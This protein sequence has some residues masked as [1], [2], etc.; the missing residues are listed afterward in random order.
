MV[1]YHVVTYYQLMWVVAYH[2]TRKKDSKAVIV[3][4]NSLENRLSKA[5][6]SKL[7]DA[8]EIHFFPY[9]KI[10]D[11]LN[12]LTDEQ[13]SQNVTDQAIKLYD[14]YIKYDLN[15]FEEINIAGYHFYFSLVLTAREIKFNIIEEAAGMLSRHHIL[16]S[17]VEKLN[18][19]QLRIALYNNLLYGDNELVQN[20]FCRVECQ[21]KGYEGVNLCNYDLMVEMKHNEEVK[22]M[23]L[24]LFI[25]KEVEYDVCGDSVLLLTQHFANLKILPFEEQALIYQYVVDYFY[26][27][28][29]LIIKPHPDDVMFYSKLF[30]NAKIIRDKFPSELLPFL[31]KEMPRTVSTVSSTAIFSVESAFENVIKFSTRMEKNFKLLNKYY[32]A[33]YTLLKIE[34]VLTLQCL[35]CDMDIVRNIIHN[36]D[37]DNKDIEIKECK[38]IEEIDVEVPL[39]I[40][41]SCGDYFTEENID[42]TNKAHSMLIVNCDYD[43]EHV[44]FVADNINNIV[45]IYISK[46]K[47]CDRDINTYYYDN[48]IDEVIYYASVDKELRKVAS[49]LEI[50]K[51]LESVGVKI[52]KVSLDEKDRELLAVKGILKATEERLKFALNKNEKLE[53]ELAQLKSDNHII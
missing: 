12:G 53:A 50:E 44:D 21:E 15:E 32:I 33:L 4:V 9:D 6:L 26:Q 28:K 11:R 46:S 31:F 43:Y 8:F 7:K 49:E 37:I 47:I 41:E 34:K 13:L 5:V 22:N 14:E 52:N 40:G 29:N 3:M 25:D 36:T 23:L 35:N 38:S 24:N 1:L 18:T 17:I 30:P 48:E 27:D 16:H 42:L 2:M 51:E 20:R 45:P 19:F 39:L 10:N